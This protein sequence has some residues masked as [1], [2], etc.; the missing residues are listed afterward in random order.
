MAKILCTAF[1]ITAMFGI[2]RFVIPA[3]GLDLTFATIF[4]DIAHVYVGGLLS[5][6]MYG[7][8]ILL[9]TKH[10]DHKETPEKTLEV[11][12]NLAATGIVLGTLGILL[13]C[14]EVVAAMVK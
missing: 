3:N 14:V 6:G 10:I 4:K 12:D 2:M 1:G 9:A 7:S 8:A 11:L 13:T 5:A